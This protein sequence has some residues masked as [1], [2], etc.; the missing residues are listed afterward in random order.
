MAA[1]GEPIWAERIAGSHEAGDLSG[2]EYAVNESQDEAEIDL[3]PKSGACQQ[4]L[5]PVAELGGGVRAGMHLASLLERGLD[6]LLCGLHGIL[7]FVETI[8]E[9]PCLRPLYICHRAELLQKLPR[10]LLDTIFIHIQ[11]LMRLACPRARRASR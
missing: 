9:S 5:C 11:T 7:V 6:S 2:F 10:H 8:Q 3:E 4:E 1:D